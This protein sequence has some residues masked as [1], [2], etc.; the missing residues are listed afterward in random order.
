M[1]KAT[2]SPEKLARL[3]KNM[4]A[5]SKK[6]LF[7]NAWDVPSDSATPETSTSQVKSS[8]KPSLLV[9]RYKEIEEKKQEIAKAGK[10]PKG[11]P[12]LLVCNEIPAR[13]LIV[14]NQ[15]DWV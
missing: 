12:N 2:L 13:Q 7:K 1:R 10:L 8:H 3:D 6:D 14:N 15:P 9:T 11:V 4:L 5:I